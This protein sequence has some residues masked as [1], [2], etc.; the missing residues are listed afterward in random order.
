MLHNM[1]RTPSILPS[2]PA[3][4]GS[5]GVW[6]N[7]NFWQYSSHGTTAS[8]PGIAVY[9]CGFGRRQW[10]HQFCPVVPHWGTPP[11]T[12]FERFDVNGTTAGSGVTNGGSYTWEAAK[13]SSTA[14]GTDPTAWNEGNFL[15]LAAGTD[16]GRQQLH[17]HREF[18]PHVCRHVLANRRRRDRDHQWARRL[19]DRRAA[20][21]AFLSAPALKT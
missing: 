17:D 9:L 13:Y 10:R 7:W 6:S 18:Q 12:L 19:V 8:V 11:P 1:L 3:V 14:A 21:R 5:T 20:T 15:R 16:A 4:L 2:R